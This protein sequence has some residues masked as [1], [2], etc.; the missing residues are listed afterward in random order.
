MTLENLDAALKAVCPDCSELA[1]PAG[2]NRYIVWQVYGH[3][4]TVGDDGVLLELPKV[5]LDV[6]AQASSDSIF[7]GVKD[8]LTALDIPWAEE[9]FSYDPE[10]ERI[11]MILQMVVY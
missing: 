1:I 10:Y 3:A 8:L 9:E 11:R 5:Q 2:K 4:Q 7:A 6:C